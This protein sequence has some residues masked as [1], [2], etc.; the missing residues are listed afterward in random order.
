MT[1]HSCTL[2]SEQVCSLKS[3]LNYIWAANDIRNFQPLINS[4]I[5]TCYMFKHTWTYIFN[6]EQTFEKVHRSFILDVIFI[7]RWQKKMSGWQ[8][9]FSRHFLANCLLN[10]VHQVLQQVSTS[11]RLTDNYLAVCHFPPPAASSAALFVWWQVNTHLGWPLSSLVSL[12]ND[13]GV[14]C[15]DYRWYFHPMKSQTVPP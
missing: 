13:G 1:E 5:I 12:L 3:L 10:A 4:W 8:P 9:G 11:S 14:S 7:H 6:M 2:Y 15:H